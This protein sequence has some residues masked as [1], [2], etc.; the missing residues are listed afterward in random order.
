MARNL[1]LPSSGSQPGNQWRNQGGAIATPVK[2]LAPL[3]KL[4]IK[5][6]FFA[7]FSKLTRSIKSRKKKFLISSVYQCE[8]YARA[9]FPL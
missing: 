7:F 9:G 6:T 3:V 2:C 4:Y 5:V 1:S 8:N